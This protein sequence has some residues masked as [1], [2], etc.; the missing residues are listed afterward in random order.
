MEGIT[1]NM[2]LVNVG[3]RL[4]VTNIRNPFDPLN[5]REI[6][7]L[8]VGTTIQ[9]CVDSVLPVS[10]GYE[11]VVSFNGVVLD[12]AIDFSVVKPIGNIAICAIPQGGGG[13]KDVLRLVSMLA[14]MVVA[15][16]LAYPTAGQSLWVGYGAA[17]GLGAQASIALGTV[18]FVTAG[19]LLVNALL[20]MNTPD[21]T[22]A[23]GDF[24]QSPTYGW[25]AENNSDREGIVFPVLYGTVRI[26]PAILSKYIE[27]MGDKQYINLL[28]V[29]AD[30]AISSI[31]ETSVRINEN[32][33]VNGTDGINFEY[34][35]GAVEQSVIQYFNDTRT[36]KAEGS[37]IGTHPVWSEVT[38]YVLGNLVSY[39]VDTTVYV[40]IQNNL[41]KI[42]TTETAYWKAL[43]DN[44]LAENPWTTVDL[45]GS[46]IEGFG[47][48][49]SCPS[50]LFYAANDGTLTENT[51]NLD[52]EYRL[53]VEGQDETWTRRQDY[54]VAELPI[55]VNRWSGGFYTSMGIWYETEIG[56]TIFADHKEGDT[57][58][59]NGYTWETYSEGEFS[60]EIRNIYMWRW[61]SGISTV[62]VKNTLLLNYTQISGKQTTPIRRI[63]YKEHVTAG[64]YQIRIR[65]HGGIV[66][67]NNSRYSNATYLEYT[68]T[69]IYDDFNYPGTALFAVRAL[70]TD[71]YSG[72]MPVCDLVPTR[73]YVSVWTGAAYEDKPANNPAWACYDIIHNSEYGGSIPHSRIIYDDFALWAAY[74]V[75]E[76][77]TC[78][79]YFD[80]GMSLN[81][82]LQTI[83]LLGRGSVVQ[84][85]SLF[86]CFIDKPVSIPAQSF[87]F[88][89]ANTTSNSFKL[90]YSDLSE[91]ANA[92]DVTYWDADDFYK[93]KTI[94]VT[95]P[96]F[97]STEQEIK[98]SSL[99]LV[100]CTSRALALRHT[101]FYLNNNRLLTISGSWVTDIN[102][103]HCL[104]WDVVEVQHDTTSWGEGGRVIA[105]GAGN[106]T[107]AIDKHITLSPGVTY[108]LK[109]V[110]ALTDVNTEYTLVS[111]DVEESVEGLT[112][113][114]TFNPVPV[115]YDLWT[116]TSVNSET[117]FMRIIRI[118]RKDDLTRTITAIEYN[119]EIYN[120]SGTLDAPETPAL[121]IYTSNVK[122][123]EILTWK[124][125]NA[126]AIQ[127]NWTGFAIRWF[128]WKRIDGATVWN[129]VG[130]T[131]FTYM[132]IPELE[133]GSTYNFCVSHTKNTSDG[134]VAL[135]IRENETTDVLYS[136]VVSTTEEIPTGFTATLEERCIALTWD[137]T[138][139][140]TIKGYS[141]YYNTTGNHA[142]DILL[143]Q[144]FLG[145]KY[146]F[147]EVLTTNHYYFSLKYVT[148]GGHS[149]NFAETEYVLPVPATIGAI[150]TELFEDGVTFKWTPNT[151]VFLRGYQFKTRVDYDSEDVEAYDGTTWTNEGSWDASWTSTIKN[152]F[153]R[154]LTGT[155]QQNYGWGKSRI[156]FQVQAFDI[157]G[158]VSASVASTYAF[159]TN[160]SVSVSVGTTT[161]MAT[162][163][164]LAAA[165]AKLPSGGGAIC[166]KNG[167]YNIPAIS[168]ED[169]N[170][171][172]F[173]ES[174]GGV[175]IR[176]TPG[177]NLFN[178][179]NLH[180]I[181]TFRDFTIE[182]QNTDIF[183]TMFNIYGDTP[184]QSTLVFST[185]RV[186]ATLKGNTPGS[187][188]DTLIYV[189][190]GDVGGQVKVTKSTVVG[191]LGCKFIDNGI[192]GGTGTRNSFF[193]SVTDNIVDT[194]YTAITIIGKQFT[195]KNNI[196]SNIFGSGIVA[197]TYV[198]TDLSCFVSENTISFYDSPGN[199]TRGINASSGKLSIMSNRIF[200]TFT[201]IV[202]NTL[203]ILIGQVMEVTGNTIVLIS[204]TNSGLPGVYGIWCSM[205]SNGSIRDNI[206]TIDSPSPGELYP[207]IGIHIDASNNNNLCNNTID[208]VNSTS[209]DVG[210]L[211][212]AASDNNK[213][214]ENK[215]SN[216]G[217][218]ISDDGTNN[219]L[220]VIGRAS[221]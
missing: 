128:V 82:A 31:D 32:S 152:T 71:K 190:Q 129:Y 26:T 39:M 113:T 159:P 94:E 161:T 174:Q 142:D 7:E 70:A 5:S 18:I 76:G 21:M 124:G 148:Y 206:I 217:T 65:F 3:N 95:A 28:F 97:D 112:I 177:Q 29:I 63:F 23:G 149:P 175:L 16:M 52:I 110:N 27:V 126:T 38:N 50:G 207:N 9:E 68:E 137:A 216:C 140:V 2:D 93:Q 133:Y 179:H 201:N 153:T 61:L 156:W 164:D 81:K 132:V 78:N 60:I 167:E 62:F 48:A 108:K 194:C 200:G 187:S 121:I 136:G 151:D 214:G 34:R 139:D 91:R 130:E 162:F 120:D 204:P 4:I 92:I 89:V 189:G 144:G 40:C 42:P 197:Y 150:T 191:E 55:S 160:K 208:M 213:G 165:I 168:L 221:F 79:I 210:I 66:P 111:P 57:Y 134:V 118:G 64:S 100:G 46:N 59:G 51:V 138:D 169:K 127:L 154:N 101:Y 182:S 75:T 180:K 85:G 196:L 146:V 173:G 24:S 215:I 116:V 205:T 53:H 131:T 20:P 209:L 155:E 36:I 115:K 186:D 43:A 183:S 6:K 13:G 84:M 56:S 107:I 192:V 106:N 176:N 212:T 17:V 125:L 86:T 198:T 199:V 41:N 170:L 202:G 25:Q 35:L 77:F 30:H 103:L 158:Q 98:K 67:S 147:N 83:G 72:S 99:S 185:D 96:D 188:A 11:Y 157:V 1:Q 44:P 143:V 172:I 123:S 47:V 19:S 105:V 211:I 102:A 74:C 49:L 109:I 122:A 22:G 166:I 104:P 37:K 184:A 135:S 171:E 195:V 88:N 178:L 58:I 181:F 14:I 220:N 87:V 8:P 119:E 80:T 73:L 10:L 90:E 141:I 193:F 69:I 203:G 163:N 54:N 114:T 15:V 219:C 33:V 12:P 218:K 117:K 45:D 145:T